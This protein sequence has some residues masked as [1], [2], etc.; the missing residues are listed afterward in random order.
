MKLFKHQQQTAEFWSSQQRIF[1]SS[2]PGT[3]KTIA[4]IAG[5]KM[6]N[7]RER[8]LVIAPLSILKPSWGD[9]ITRFAPEL[10]YAV[11]HGDHTKRLKAF[12]STAEIVV[13]N[14]DGV[15]WL[16]KN[17]S[18]LANFSHLVVD[19]FTAF[20]NRTTQR[21]KALAQVAKSFEY[22]SMLSGTP[23]SNKITDIWFPATIIDQGVRLGTNYFRF[24]NEVCTPI[25]LPYTNNATEWREKEGAREYV[26][27]C[28]KDIT[29]RHVFEEC[30]DIPEHSEHTMLVEMPPKVMKE[31]QELKDHA[32]ISF[33]QGN[34]DAQ[35]AGILAKKL[36]QLLSGAIYNEDGE[37]I[38]CHPHRYELV[39]DLI[40]QR[41][42]CVVAFN[43]RHER[44]AL[45]K[46][47]DKLKIPY[48]IID[49]TVSVKDRE[50]VVADFQNGKLK[51]IFAQPQSAGHGLTLTAGT[52]TIWCSP[53]YNAEHFVQFN[54][55][56][57]RTGQK[58]K[59]ETVM[60]AARNTI[61][62]TVYEKLNGKVVRLEEL[63]QLFAEFSKTTQK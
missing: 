58:K 40:Q 42:Q 2:D 61:E 43:W 46:L 17:L 50:R 48:G 34:I 37:V 45:A 30:T 10:T 19:E 36:L 33:S 6:S 28:L 59:T 5:Y 12:E 26:A 18:L 47:A 16:T 55:R 7:V 54:R 8:M 60:I 14:H 22:I 24:Q 9:D 1:D 41:E 15:K 3:G 20:K 38:D 51:V 27:D 39:L 63:L 49:G 53:T 52:S 29:V 21:S 62:E 35:H 32:F 4:A 56:I 44:I 57:Y 25:P 13:I 31:Y 11:A 23:N